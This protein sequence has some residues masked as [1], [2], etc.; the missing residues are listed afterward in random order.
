MSRTKKS[1][2]DQSILIDISLCVIL[3]LNTRSQYWNKGWKERF[4]VVSF[5]KSSQDLVDK[6]LEMLSSTYSIFIIA[7]VIDMISEGI[8]VVNSEFSPLFARTSYIYIYIVRS[9]L[10]KKLVN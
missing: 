4:W 2:L 10:L 7:M 3:C 5:H 9:V 6:Y 1:H 8:R